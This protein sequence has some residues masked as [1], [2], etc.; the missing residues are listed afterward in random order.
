MVC[1]QSLEAVGVGTIDIKLKPFII[2]LLGVVC[3]EG[4]GKIF[5]DTASLDPLVYLCI[6]RIIE[7]LFLATIMFIFDKGFTSLGLTSSELIPGLKNGLIWSASFGLIA[8]LAA[9][10]LFFLRIDPVALIHTQLPSDPGKVALLFLVGGIIG[11]VAEEVFFR[12]LVYGFFRRWGVVIALVAST[13]FFVFVHPIGLW[14]PI[15]QIIGGLLFALSY[16]Y[17]KS[18]LVPI[19]IHV[20]GNWALFTI[21][22]VA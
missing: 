21:S 6:I 16:E 2:S 8:I 5:S 14:V 18:L 20:I 9:I 15:T 19:T 11:P 1:L 10:M 4:A 3:I 22:L 17:G 12:G 7:I 13:T